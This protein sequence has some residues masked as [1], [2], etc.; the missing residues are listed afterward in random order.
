M[1]PQLPLWLAV[2]FI[3]TTGCTLYLFYR[4]TRHS[5]PI[6]LCL[7]AWLLLQAIIT[8]NGVYTDTA[9]SPPRIF[10]FGIL[11]PM[12]VIVLLFVTKGGRQ[13]IDSLP[14]A[15]LTYLH[16]VRIPVEIVLFGLF[17][18]DAVPQLMTF[19]GRN[20]DIL[21]GITAPLVA[22][23]GIGKKK[24]SRTMLLIW[25][26]VCLGLLLNIVIHA[27]LSAPSPLQQLAFDQPNIA[28]GYFP[29]SWLPT[30]V[31]PVVLFA[32]LAAIRRLYADHHFL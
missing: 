11:P 30:F 4:A 16:I 3:L 2:V 15:Q 32:H 17:L 25:N 19:E 27:F 14:L 6:V 28:I 29:F 23:Y 12:L 22:Y 26:F 21:A 18:H 13:F 10:L 8:L 1:I 5:R 20:F 31:V 9:A 7:V 24:M